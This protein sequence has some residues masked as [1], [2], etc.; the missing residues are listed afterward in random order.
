MLPRVPAPLPQPLASAAP[1]EVEED[2]VE[3]GF[4][5]RV[6]IE[7]QAAQASLLC[8][9]GRHAAARELAEGILARD[10]SAPRGQVALG[11]ALA[12]AGDAQGALNAFA[13]AVRADAD[14]PVCVRA[15]A[16][17]LARLG[18]H[19]EAAQAYRRIAGPGRGEVKD[20]AALA[21][22]LRRSGDAQ[23]A[24]ELMD[25]VMRRDPH[26]LEPLRQ[27]AETMAAEGRLDAAADM[28]EQLLSQ[29]RPPH[30]TAR[31]L[32]ESLM[33]RAGTS[34]RVRAAC[35]KAFL[36][37]GRAFACV[38]LLGP[39]VAR[40]PDDLA[41]TRLLG[42]AYARLGAGPL[43][44]E[45]LLRVAQAGRADAR[46]FQ[47]L[48]EVY[49]ERGDASAGLRALGH[50]R[51]AMPRDVGI[52]R[53][54]ARALAAAGDLEGAIRE[55]RAAHEAAE[56]DDAALEDELDRITERAHAKRIKGLEARLLA[57]EDDAAARL[58]L[59]LALARRGDLGDALVHLRRAAEDR[60]LCGEVVAKAEQIADEWGE[61]P[62]EIAVLL[63]DL[64]EAAEAVH[65][66]IGVLERYLAQRPEDAELRLR[67]LELCARSDRVQD[68][69][70]GLS[71]FLEE[72]PAAVL[73]RA[74]ALGERV[75]L[76]EGI[77]SLGLPLARARR[78]LGDLEGAGELYR[79]FLEAAPDHTEAR[80]EYARLLESAGRAAEAYQVLA[81]L[82]E[83][84]AGSTAELERL[85]AL[86]LAAGRLEEAEELLRRAVR[87]EPDDLALRHALEATSARVR[88]QRIR[89]L[90]GSSDPA[91]RLE[92]AGLYAEQGHDAEAIQFLRSV[93]RLDE[94]NPQLS[95][96][97]FAAERF[98]RR[99]LLG[100]AEA[101]YRRAA[102]SLGYAPGSDPYKDLIY[103]VA[104][105]YEQGAERRAARRVYLELH[106]LDPSYR[107]VA[108]RLEALAEDVRGAALGTGEEQ[109]LELIDVGA[110]LGTI[111]ETLQQSD[112]ALEP[113]VLTD[114]RRST[115]SLRTP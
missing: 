88:E 27:Q 42:L 13:R 25:D 35:A 62:R 57:D 19:A 102:Q 48:G 53:A 10:P 46:V 84:G 54:L 39:L 83:G 47:A 95:Y 87:R 96:L 98:A 105:L 22:A 18:R 90:Q 15:Y 24:R 111:F 86:A 69:V 34:L 104:A 4:L 80:V 74:V 99:G 23:G 3:R 64:H 71:D 32:A 93:G 97:S 81:V 31:A 73:E 5:T 8:L 114:G 30:A 115:A 110:P 78:R 65:E 67:C 6:A 43:A 56:S 112:L 52:R 26:S 63:V 44:E 101:A 9:A 59:A 21:E 14:D 17:H 72:A 38:Q 50:A 113:E 94:S 1:E 55:L 45:H 12:G 85:A 68:A 36:E 75:A 33:P 16:Q 70:A 100:R 106:A 41:L 61:L 49:L 11:E 107:D 77:R 66:A 108:A 103:R 79:R 109:V 82:V 7:G 51:D 20:A 89:A 60:A 58:E 37:S 2:P 29:E 91:A 92:L 76:G 28:L 40:S